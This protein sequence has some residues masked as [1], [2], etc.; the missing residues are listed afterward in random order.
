LST[1]SLA[2]AGVRVDLAVTD[3]GAVRVVISTDKPSI[4]RDL[5]VDDHPMLHSV[6]A[7][8]GLSLPGEP[9]PGG[10]FE[11]TVEPWKGQTFKVG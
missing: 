3:E 7:L 4:V 5:R 9:T 2:H 8:G 6:I 11:V 1:A 10:T